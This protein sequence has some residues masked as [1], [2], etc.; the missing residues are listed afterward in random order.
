MTTCQ[1][2]AMWSLTLTK[3]NLK[4][5]YEKLHDCWIFLVLMIIFNLVFKHI[6]ELKLA[7]PGPHWSSYLYTSLAQ[8]FLRKAEKEV[9]FLLLCSGSETC[10]S[11]ALFVFVFSLSPAGCLQSASCCSPLFLM[12]QLSRQWFNLL[13]CKK[14][15]QVGSKVCLQRQVVNNVSMLFECWWWWLLYSN[16]K[17]SRA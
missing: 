14:K 7:Q 6:I 10:N 5:V 17:E 11:I 12:M 8:Y 9:A 4:T 2:I 13:R 3:V 16:L 1:A 15:K